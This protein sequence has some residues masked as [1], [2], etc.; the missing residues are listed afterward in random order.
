MIKFGI[1]VALDPTVNVAQRL[2]SLHVS[3]LVDIFVREGNWE[4]ASTEI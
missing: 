3:C 4:G 1:V 2:E